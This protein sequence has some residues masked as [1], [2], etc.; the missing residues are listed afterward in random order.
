MADILPFID[1]ATATDHLAFVEEAATALLKPGAKEPMEHIEKRYDDVISALDWFLDQRR[2]DEALRTAN[3]LYR[4]WIS[5]RRFEDGA[6]MFDRVLAPERGDEHLRGAAY[7][8]AGMMPFWLGDDERAK[9][10]FDRS[11]EIAREL[12]DRP[13]ASRALGGLARVAMRSDV[14]EC[15]RLAHEAL[16]TSDSVGDVAGRSNALHLLG[17]GAQIAGD[18]PEARQWMTQRL[19]LVRSTN[20]EFLVASEAANLA[21]VERQLGNLDRAEELERESLMVGG[22]I[23]DEFT[24]PF[25]ISGLAAICVERG[26]NQRAATLLGAAE[27]LMEAHHMAW[28][29]DERPHYEHMLEVLP[30][31]MGAD[32]FEHA[33]AAGKALSAAEAVALALNEGSISR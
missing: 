23:G 28:P 30:K 5:S 7:T 2:Y 33:R 8:N 13:L 1:S 29:P 10:L 20:E 32:D 14:A 24:K 3:S 6:L 4:Y 21:M 27:A 11:L 12:D 15:R 19:D 26:Q 18:L 22:R 17:V 25:A 16:E 31:A 9:A